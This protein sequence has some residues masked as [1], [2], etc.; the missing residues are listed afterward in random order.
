MVNF[1]WC[2]PSCIIINLYYLN[3]ILV[4][5]FRTQFLLQFFQFALLTVVKLEVLVALDSNSRVGKRV[6]VK[7]TH[8][9]TFPVPKHRELSL[10]SGSCWLPFA[11]P[12]PKAQLCIQPTTAPV[13]HHQVLS[14]HRWLCQTWA[15]WETL[16]VV[17]SC[18]H[19]TVFPRGKIN[20][21]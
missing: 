6:L 14:W 21:K 20:G 16:Q 3:L 10:P 19:G 4:L 8:G 13:P 7:K 12:L 2:L 9:A 1:F 18:I 5:V 17:Q 11:V 15:T